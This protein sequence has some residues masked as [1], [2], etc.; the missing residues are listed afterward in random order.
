MT[1]ERLFDDSTTEAATL[2]D[3]GF[4]RL[5][6][7]LRVLPVSRSNWWEGVKSGRFPPSVK[8]SEGITAWDVDDI[9]RCIETYRKGKKPWIPVS[10]A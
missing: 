4:V 8:I 1:I 2:P 3:T 7:I 6:L 5:P 9:R 10:K